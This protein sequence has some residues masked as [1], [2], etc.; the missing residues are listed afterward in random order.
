M[1]Y[2][3]H[4]NEKAES[5]IAKQIQKF[6]LGWDT[7]ATM[8]EIEGTNTF[9]ESKFGEDISVELSGKTFEVDADEIEFWESD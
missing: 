9:F 2:A 3:A 8:T 4:L 1:K 6:N 5:S 7:W